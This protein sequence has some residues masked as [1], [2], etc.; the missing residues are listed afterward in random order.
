MMGSSEPGRP[1][2]KAPDAD[3]N[4]PGAAMVFCRQSFV[5]QKSNNGRKNLPSRKG[6]AGKAIG[7]ETC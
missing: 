1:N 5:K 6:D 3:D 4:D 2:R 7:I